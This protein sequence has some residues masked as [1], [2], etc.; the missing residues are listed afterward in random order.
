MSLTRSIHAPYAAAV[1]FGALAASGVTVLLAIC[2][3]LQ[4]T[5]LHWEQALGAF[6]FPASPGYAF[7][8]GFGLHVAASVAAAWVYTF[9]FRATG[10]HGVIAGTAVGVLH[11][12]V[13]G[14]LLHLMPWPV[15]PDG[16]VPWAPGWF[17]VELGGG[18]AVLLL[19]VHLCFG[20]FLGA[21]IARHEALRH[22]SIDGIR[23]Q[24]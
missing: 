21:C 4:L 20:A 12:L 1:A 9:I 18:T 5:T 19:L 2:R 7:L 24:S 3:S 15:L 11:W 10:R 13:D 23:H 14:A 17:A 22:I 16:E 8:A 6:F